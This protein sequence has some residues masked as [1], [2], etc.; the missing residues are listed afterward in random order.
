M[1]QSTEFLCPSAA[2]DD[3][4]WWEKGDGHVHCEHSALGS[5]PG[6]DWRMGAVGAGGSVSREAGGAEADSDNTPPNTTVV[7]DRRRRAAGRTAYGNDSEQVYA[8]RGCSDE[9][10]HWAVVVVVCSVLLWWL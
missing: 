7:Q 4:L 6:F 1:R 8:K 3:V 10:G 9:C 2:D 5:V